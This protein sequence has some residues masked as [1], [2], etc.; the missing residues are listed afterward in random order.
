MRD[1]IR[2]PSGARAA[3]TPAALP[4]LGRACA[5]E[6]IGTYIL[7]FFGC[8]SVMSAVI[9][10]AQVGLWQ[11]AVV[12]GFGISLA[13]YATLFYLPMISSGQLL[14]DNRLGLELFPAFIVLGQLTRWRVAFAAYGTI[15]GGLAL[16][17]MARFA[18]GY[19]VG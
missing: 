9:T 1:A 14:S 10:G 11:V 4:A 6:L 16:Y 19:W 12:W 17:L 5:A 7:A 18:L 15:A 3:A 8:G 2:I 13:I